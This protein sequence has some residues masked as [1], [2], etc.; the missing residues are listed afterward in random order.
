MPAPVYCTKIASRLARTYTDKHGLKDL[1]REVLGVDLSKQQQ[2]SDWGADALSDARSPM[3]PPTCCICTRSRT[4]WTPCSFAKGARTSPPPASASARPG[5]AGS[6]GLGGRGC[7]CPFV[8]RR[9]PAGPYLGATMALEIVNIAGGPPDSQPGGGLG[10]NQLAAISEFDH[11]GTQV[12]AGVGR[13]DERVFRAAVRHNRR[14]RVL[15][16][17]I[18]IGVA[19]AV[20]GVLVATTWLCRCGCSPRCRS[21][22]A[23]WWCPAP[24]SCDA[25]AAAR[26]FLGQPPLRLSAQ[27]AAQDLTKPDV[28][29]RKASAPTWRCRTISP[30]RPP[31]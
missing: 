18:P 24:R 27:A 2:L 14:V 17:A 21:T 12:F 9:A 29:E 22:S 11:A 3:R 31:R 19:V 13:S 8:D 23:I 15:R 28:I 30:T 10:M 6:G 20:L 25:A 26:G 1:V 4:S 7:L 5:P 16:L